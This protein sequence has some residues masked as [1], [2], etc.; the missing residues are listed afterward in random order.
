[1]HVGFTNDQLYEGSAG[2]S[3]LKKKK[4]GACGV[5]RNF[6]RWM[7]HAWTRAERIVLLGMG[8]QQL[9]LGASNE[10]EN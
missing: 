1:M 9:A 3:S 8:S 10:R 2:S 4:K 5:Y 6:I 7:F